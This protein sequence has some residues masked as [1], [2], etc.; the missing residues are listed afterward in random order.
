MSHTNS[1]LVLVL[2]VGLFL[3]SGS[4]V[5]AA[6]GLDTIVG[7]FTTP[8]E[9]GT[10][11]WVLSVREGDSA[12]GFIRWSR[13]FEDG[14]PTRVRSYDVRYANIHVNDEGK[15]EGWVAATLASDT[16]GPLPVEPVW[17]VGRY[18]D[19]GHPGSAGDYYRYSPEGQDEATARNAAENWTAEGLASWRS[20]VIDKGNFEIRSF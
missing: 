16:G 2:T 20:T 3:P 7:A 6:G 4:S 13:T 10:S 12:V 9:A 11:S 1:M 19:G 5:R 17:F 18:V 14:S 8:R 15:Q